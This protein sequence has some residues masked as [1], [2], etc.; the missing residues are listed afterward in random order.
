MRITPHSRLKQLT[1]LILIFRLIFVLL[2]CAAAPG[3]WAGDRIVE[4]AYFEDAGGHLTLA[5][6][7]ARPLTPYAGVLSRGYT[8][9]AIWLRLTIDP[10]PVTASDA[11]ATLILRVRPTYL[12]E[13]A[14]FDPLQPRATPRVVG[15]RHA[16]SNNEYQSLNFNFVIPRGEVSRSVWLRLKTSSTS[17]ILVEALD[18]SEN[19]Q[20]DRR[21]ELLNSGLLA[22]LLLF[23]IWAL[24]QWFTT[25][26]VVVGAFVIKQAVTIVY[27]LA[28]TG[29]LRIFLSGIVQ[30]D[31]LDRFTSLTIVFGPAAAIF[32]DYSLLREYSP[33]RWG[34]RVLWLFLALL[35]VEVALIAGG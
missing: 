8:S 10:Q 14:L 32:F 6:V 31:W 4:R 28:Y 24:I 5:E 9:S 26:E 12:D 17:L 13:V 19:V 21:I 29:Y 34:L 11:P 3:S 2:L 30:P 18:P 15:D 7:Q 1:I 22:L 33:P 20:S 35:P 16:W 23:M 25:R 27:L